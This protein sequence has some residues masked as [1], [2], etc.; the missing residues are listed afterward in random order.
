MEI[1]STTYWC[2]YKTT[3]CHAGVH[4][5]KIQGKEVQKCDLHYF[6]LEADVST[7][8]QFGYSNEEWMLF[9]NVIQ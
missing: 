3:A 1:D 6:N 4:K 5:F 9:R 2:D 7:T 8:D